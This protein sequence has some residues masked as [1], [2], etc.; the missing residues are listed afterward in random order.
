M[1]HSY[2]KLI[3]V[4][5][6]AVFKQNVSELPDDIHNDN[7]WVLQKFQKGEP[8][9]YIEHIQT[10]T[11]FAQHNPDSLIVFSG[12]RTRAESKNW[13]EASS[14]H[15]IYLKLNKGRPI[16]GTALEPYARDSFENL[17]FSLCR[18]SEVTN[19]KPEHL[20][21][22]GW[23]FKQKRFELHSNSLNIPQ[24]KFTYIGVNDPDDLEVA[25]H[26]ENKVIEL[27]QQ[28][29]FGDYGDLQQKRVERN[30]FHD[31]PPYNTDAYLQSTPNNTDS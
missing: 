25:I 11:Q 2:K 22:F 30:P 31:T 1:L 14:Y 7:Y 9:Y 26:G 28:F 5:G 19:R 16:N 24:N 27:F 4:P 10:A 17:L 21:V 8:K 13:S 18:F 20:Y 3:I 6:H 12:G 23:K 29:P 15:S